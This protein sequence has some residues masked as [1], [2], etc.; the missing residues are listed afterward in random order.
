MHS[1]VIMRVLTDWNLGRVKSSRRFM[2]I[3][4]L[5]PNLPIACDLPFHSCQFELNRTIK[6]T[7]ISRIKYLEFIHKYLEFIQNIML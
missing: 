5:H 1:Y 6:H 7:K 4:D 2:K 3:I